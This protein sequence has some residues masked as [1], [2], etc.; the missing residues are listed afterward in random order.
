[1]ARAAALKTDIKTINDAQVVRKDN[2]IVLS[3]N[4]EEVN[5]FNVIATVISFFKDDKVMTIDDGTGSIV[6]QWFD[7]SY[8]VSVGETV[9]VIGRIRE[10]DYKYI[11]PE[12][13]K[14]ITDSAWVDV[15]KKELLATPVSITK[16]KPAEADPDEKALKIIHECDRGDGADMDEVIQKLGSN[17]EELIKRLLMAGEAFESKPGKI[18]LL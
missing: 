12:V 7:D 15:R 16:E 9:L 13:V 4:G 2:A 11:F 18:R 3:L 8:D 10:F 6:V 1:M 5:R 17:G 14:K